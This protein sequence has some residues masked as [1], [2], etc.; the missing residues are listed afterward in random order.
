ML[1]ECEGMFIL[2]F[3]WSHILHYAQKTKDM[4]QSFTSQTFLREA[5]RGNLRRIS[6]IQVWACIYLSYRGHEQIGDCGHGIEMMSL[7]LVYK[8]RAHPS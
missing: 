4:A 3:L 7:S 6:D 8:R 5:S 1:E 2:E